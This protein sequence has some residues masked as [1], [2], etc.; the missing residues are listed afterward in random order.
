[1][2][3]GEV[4]NRVR[5][6]L[7][8]CRLEKGLT[9][10]EVGNIVGKAKT[11]VAS[12]EQGKSLPDVDTLMKLAN[13]YGKTMDFMYGEDKREKLL[14][15]ISEPLGHTKDDAPDVCQQIAN[16]FA[17]LNEEQQ[18]AILTL[19]ALMLDKENKP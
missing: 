18:N 7:I 3:D 14:D 8:R 16:D 4:R 5:E 11:A 13:Y 12:W 19:M 9:Q 10:T 17:L 6:N 1:M 15:Y 2:K